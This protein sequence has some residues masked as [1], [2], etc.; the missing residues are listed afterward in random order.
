MRLDLDNF[1]AYLATCAALTLALAL[2][3]R[4]G[5]S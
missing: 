4:W 3:Y 2:L 1:W 5:T